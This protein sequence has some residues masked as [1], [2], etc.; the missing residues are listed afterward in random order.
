M[1]DN[2]PGPASLALL[3]TLPEG[4]PIWGVASLDDE[5][6]VVREGASHIQVYRYTTLY[7]RLEVPGLA[8]ARDLAACH[9]HSCLYISDVGDKRND[10]K[11]ESRRPY[12]IHRFVSVLYTNYFLP[13]PLFVRIW[14]SY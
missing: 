8:A 13:V 11:A 12:V 7:R 14:M 10:G 1:T 2:E 6:F 3:Y 9:L 4:R 5:Q